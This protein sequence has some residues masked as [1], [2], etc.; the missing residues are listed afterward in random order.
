MSTDFH[1][2]TITVTALIFAGKL[3]GNGLEEAAHEVLATFFE[4]MPDEQKADLYALL[5]EKLDEDMGVNHAQAVVS[6]CLWD[7]QNN[8]AAR[9]G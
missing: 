5:A 4:D 2:E 7:N 3:G 6:R 1:P 8:W 9:H